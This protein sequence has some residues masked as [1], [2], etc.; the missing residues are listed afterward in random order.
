MITRRWLLQ[1]VAAVV[2]T[3]K[4]GSLFASQPRRVVLELQSQQ[5][6]EFILGLIYAARSTNRNPCRGFA[7]ESMFLDHVSIG[8]SINGV[9][10]TRVTLVPAP[11]TTTQDVQVGEFTLRPIFAS[12]VWPDFEHWREVVG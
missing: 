4:C 1:A 11:R 6:G 3:M 5:D 2:A 10:T 12:S 9:R 8:P 7:A